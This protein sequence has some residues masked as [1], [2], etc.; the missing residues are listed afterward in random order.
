MDEVLSTCFYSEETLAYPL[1]FWY[2]ED[3]I[4]AGILP[5]EGFFN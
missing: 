4:Y 3:C 5:S 1:T 2:K